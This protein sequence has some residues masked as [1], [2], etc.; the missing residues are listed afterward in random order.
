MIGYVVVPDLWVI[1]PR[2]SHS[3]ADD[4]SCFSKNDASSTPLGQRLRVQA[5]PAMCG[6]NAAAT[7]T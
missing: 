4:A 5:R 2:T 7:L 3:G 1:D 6:T